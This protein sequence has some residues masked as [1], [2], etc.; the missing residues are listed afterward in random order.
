M[1]YRV[2]DTTDSQNIQT[3]RT[4]HISI[5]ANHQPTVTALSASFNEDTDLTISASDFG[6]TDHDSDA[7]HSITITH[8][9]DASHGH[10]IL[11]GHVITDG[12][13]ILAADVARLIFRPVANY[14]GSATFSYTANDG[15]SDSSE[16]HAQLT[17]TSVN[18]AP[19]I[20]LAPVTPLTGVVTQ[21]DV[22][23]GD[24]HQFS[25]GLSAGNFGTLTVDP[26]SGVYQYVPNGQITGM[27]YNQGTGHYTGQ[28][29]FEVTVTD[30]AGESASLFVTFNVDGTVTAP[31]VSGQAP[32]VATHIN[33]QPTVTH[34]MP[35]MLLAAHHVTNHVTVDLASTSDSG[36]SH[37][38][39]LTND[40]TPTISGHTD[41]PFSKVNIYDG[42]KVVGSG[43]SDAH[44]HYQVDSSLL[45]NGVHNISVIALAPGSVVPVVSSRLAIT[46]D[47][48]APAPTISVDTVTR[49]NVISASE[50]QSVI[51]IT[52]LS[53]G[54][55]HQGDI[56]TL[57]VGRHSYT[58]QID[59]TGHY[60]IDVPGAELEK[61]SKLNVS[62]STTD[63]AGNTATTSLEHHYDVD[64]SVGSPTIS[65]ENPGAD[66]LYSKAEIAHGAAG[67]ITATVHA[68]S[69]AKVGEHL[70]V[71]G[72]DHV[73]DAQSI[74][75]GVNVEVAPNSIVKAVMTD[76][77][78][79]VNSA[80]NVA[81]GAKPEPIVVTAPSGS[82]H[83]SASLGAPVLM[84]TSQPVPT[85][86]QGWKILV[87]G[88]YHTTYTSQW[89]TL[90]IDPKTGDLSYQEHANV[91]TGPHG[92]AQNVG[93]HADHFEIALQGSHQDDVLL[94]VQV[95]I[96]SHGPGH[97]GKLTLGSEVLDM[98]VTPVISHNPPPPPPAPHV[99]ADEPMQDSENTVFDSMTI[100]SELGIH[101]GMVEDDS[102][103]QPDS[104]HHYMDK[105]GISNEHHQN[106]SPGVQTALPDDIDV[107]LNDDEQNKVDTGHADSHHDVHSGVEHLHDADTDH[108]H[109][110]PTLPDD[111]NS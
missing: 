77:H 97:S 14:N 92:S 81:A 90:S 48:H 27:R 34:S 84:P 43:Y 72:V 107:V 32:S 78:G 67:T 63:A 75:H 45:S 80:I 60:S 21:T 93:V 64:T 33:S 69:D 28:D 17:I 26:D 22:D 102:H 61:V 11:D 70:N 99:L 100:M 53:S 62:I 96:L 4:L 13:A 23:V 54:D 47:T 20:H 73:L 2:V 7:L 6:Y 105:L 44:G 15:H 50:S 46:I 104:V 98:T 83:I 71:N 35:N 87:N 5:D 85:A 40:E 66:N 9:P 89:G 18:D 37:S 111:L 94:H 41:I 59:A 88:H 16:Q 91:H 110:D 24:T 55:A 30:K 79:N 19:A 39:N 36:R 74:Q 68:A 38:D 65:F 25:V 1:W 10:L 86:Q 8:T 49:D 52:G 82:H 56:V 29:T 3:Q 103:H 76:E 108:L 12:S 106:T 57:S 51:A 42:S 31:V 58:G 109:D 95:S 101:K